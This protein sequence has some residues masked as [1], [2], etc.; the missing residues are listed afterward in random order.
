MFFYLLSYIC[1]F[2]Y[3]FYE[4]FMKKVYTKIRAISLGLLFSL[5]FG[6]M[7]GLRYGIGTDYFTY[8][9]L[10]ENINNLDSLL[11]KNNW[12][13]PGFKF[14]IYF[15]NQIGFTEPLIFLSFALITL[16]LLFSGIKKN[17]KH[18]VFSFFVYFCVFY[19]GY[20]FNVMRQGIVMA[21][22]VYLLKDIQNR[23]LLKVA[24]LTLIG[25]TIH[26]SA[27]FIIM[28]YFVYNLNLTKWRIISIISVS[29]ILILINEYYSQLVFYLVPD[30]VSQKLKS[31]I[32]FRGHGGLSIINVSQRLFLLI[33][34]ILFFDKLKLKKSNFQ[35]LFNI[36]VLGFVLYAIF[37]I[38]GLFATRIN[39]FFRILEVILIPYLI[40]VQGKKDM[41]VFIYLTIIL[42]IS[43]VFIRELMDPDNFPF[44]TIFSSN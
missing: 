33:L 29:L 23:N 44:K 20:V 7:A 2:F 32:E 1:L 26:Y 14:L 36:Y 11:Y 31:Y 3:S 40:E 24:I 22:F 21:L 13:E 35:G 19:I 10:F 34:F 42:W 6:L 8:L 12:V 41:K 43:A 15:F 9:Y 4:I 38:Q 25:M 37:S 39:M 18:V 17:T 16:S 5:F 30:Y 28:A 27:I